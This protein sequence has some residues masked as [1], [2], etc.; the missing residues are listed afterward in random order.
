MVQ[1]LV[2]F[3]LHLDAS[4]LLKTYMNLW[5]D[6]FFSW[7]VDSRNSITSLLLESFEIAAMPLVWLI[8]RGLRGLADFRQPS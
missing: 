5:H 1:H 8:F 3:Q 7:Q 4:T 6:F 2:L